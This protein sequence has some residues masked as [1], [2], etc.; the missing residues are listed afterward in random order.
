MRRPRVAAQR[1]RI[2]A[3]RARYERS[4]AGH[5]SQE[6]KELDFV[7]WITVLGASL[8]WSAVPLIILLSS[9]ANERIDDDISRH[10]GLSHE[11]ARIVHSLF[12][13]SP[14]HQLEPILT[15]FLFSCAGVIATVSSLQHVYER[16]FG[17]AHRGWRDL[18]RWI[19]WTALV[20]TA[21]A[22]EATINQ[23]V[24][25]ATGPLLPDLMTLVVSTLFFWWTM[26]FLLAGRTSWH[27]L[28][29]PAIST[30][31][32][33]FGFGLFSSLYFSPLIV[34]DS[35]TYGAIGVVFTLL[36]WFFLMGAVLVLGAVLGA[37]WQ[38]RAEGR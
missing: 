30:G 21:L 10:I 1:E 13:G 35:R 36:T 9:F 31:A 2:D 18:P 28:A 7:N 25:H 38:A 4:W 15:G 20:I 27:R 22:I 24:R 33:W 34:S 17:L 26:H 3:A 16:I 23:G 32:L 11:G 29:R 19:L 14:S 12:R 5:I 6:L 37:A 8:L